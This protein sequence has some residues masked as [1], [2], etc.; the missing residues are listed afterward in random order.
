M[1]A[2]KAFVACLLTLLLVLGPSVPAVADTP[3]NFVYL[4][5]ILTPP[6][7][8]GSA[9]TLISPTDGSSSQSLIPTFKWEN[10][11]VTGVTEV[12]LFVSLHEDDYPDHWEYQVTSYNSYFEEEQYDVDNLSTDTTY[13]WQ[14][15]MKCGE[16]ESPHSEVWSFTTGS[17]GLILPAPKLL[18]PENGAEISE[19]M[20][21]ITLT[22]EPVEGAT[23]YK[24]ILSRYDSGTWLISYTR[25]V[26][27]SQF[28]IPINLFANTSYRWTV[29][30]MND[31]ALS[32]S[33]S[34]IFVTLDDL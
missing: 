14:V 18:S 32:P 21:P 4:P 30:P 8:C 19:D 3:E 17:D 5:L 9:P 15:F 16:V 23:N 28:L 7:S 33:S 13:Y 20:L 6:G 12:T 10:G 34:F 1:R 26:T 2:F 22:W 27:D 11:D 25:T 29:Q 24:V 31:Y